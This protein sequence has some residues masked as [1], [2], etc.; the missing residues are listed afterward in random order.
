[1]TRPE[2]GEEPPAL[3]RLDPDRASQSPSAPPTAAA[4]AAG[5]RPAFDPRPYRIIV[6][7]IG[8]AVIVVVGVL[9]LIT[10]GRTTIGVPP[11]KRL[12]L[13]AA[14]L[15]T[16]TLVGDANPHPTCSPARHDPRALNLCLLAAERPIVLAFFVTSAPACIHE[17]DA[18]QA[19]SVRIHSVAYAAVGVA[20]ERSAVA[21]LVRR[22][23]WTIPVADDPDGVV[24]Q[25]YGVVACPL[26]ELAARGGIVQ[27][28]LIGNRWQ[29]AAA[30]GP[31]VRRLAA[32]R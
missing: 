16:S 22:H 9:Q 1:M 25:L 24:Q 21:G 11:G 5:P 2:E 7:V 3:Q 28:R 4:R 27:T 12:H 10:H 15:A 26:L 32:G 23:G 17:V 31:D 13:F 6:G 8:L 14:P 29:T 19:L 20:G 30:L 18:L